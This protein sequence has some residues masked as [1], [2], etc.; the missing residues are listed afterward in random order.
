MCN[1]IL[2]RGGKLNMSHSL[3]PVMCVGDDEKGRGGGGKRE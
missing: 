1:I 3:V 2:K